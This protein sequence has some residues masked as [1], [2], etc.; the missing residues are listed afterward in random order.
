MI[1]PPIWD[2]LQRILPVLQDISP[3]SFH[4][5]CLFAASS[6]S[7]IFIQPEL[8]KRAEILKGHYDQDDRIKEIGYGWI[9]NAQIFIDIHIDRCII[10]RFFFVFRPAEPASCQEL[11][12][13]NNALRE[14][15][16]AKNLLKRN[17]TPHKLEK[18][19]GIL[20]KVTR[21]VLV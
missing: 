9:T 4:S 16:K 6:L 18:C 8:G 13:R 20:F 1:Q 11:F 21:A 3:H 10:F 14:P 2:S 12:L 5:V 15:A 17:V 7:F 19:P